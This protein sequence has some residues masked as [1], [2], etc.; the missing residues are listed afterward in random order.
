M[1]AADAVPVAP[2]VPADEQAWRALAQAVVERLARLHQPA[3]EPGS[4][5]AAEIERADAS[6]DAARA[7]FRTMLQLPVPFAT[8][9]DNARLAPADAE[10]L[11]VAVGCELDLRLARLIGALQDEVGPSRL[12][13]QIADRILRDAG[14]GVAAAIGLEAP[15]RRARLV[16]VTEDGPWAQHAVVVHPGVIWALV[17][18]TA[19]D[20]GLPLGT[21][22][23]DDDDPADD[24]H[25]FVL[26]S[27]PD[28]IRRRE[29]A[30]H[31]AAA[32]RFLVAPQPTE[33]A[34]WDALVR[35][36]TLSGTGVIIELPDDVGAELTPDGKRTIAQAD[37]LAWGVTAR[38]ELPIG[39]M[40][41]RSWV[42]LE[43]PGH[44]ATDE[45]WDAAVGPQRERIHRLSPTQLDLVGKA[46]VARGGDLDAA[47]RR[48][49]S[50]RLEQLAQRMR[51]TRTWDDIVLSPARLE[52][53]RGIVDRYRYA[54]VVY[55]RWGFV[56][57]P[58]RG[59]VSLFSGPS[60]TGKTL[61]AEI[62]AGDLGLDVFKLD[63]SSVVSKYIGETEKNLEQIFEAAGGSNVVL[64]FDEADSLFGKRSE[65]KD[66]RDRYANIEVSYLLQRLERYDGVVVLATNFEK[67][68]DEAF[69]RRIHTRVEFVVPAEEE[70]LT[71]WTRNFPPDAP[72]GDIDL[73]FLAKRFEL[74]GGSIRNAAVHAAFLAASQESPITMELTVRAIAREMR[75]L[76][77]LLK[78]EHFGP[79][80]DA[81]VATD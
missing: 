13:L 75:K 54:S 71:I 3:A 43:A 9:A 31:H 20:P 19:V 44:A 57:Q 58:S 80:F 70:R 14:S 48:L 26:V 51:P 65:V 46:W 49:V 15:L 56:P 62:I 74:S 1:A 18:D 64:F 50:G 72:L 76:G 52:Q 36:A 53:L 16:D 47:V 39:E 77:R 25:A 35:E 59:L 63:L 33:R 28:R 29:T 45:E 69:L 27:G 5:A 7:A 2:A 21:V 10:L 40:P 17:G 41:M 60:G 66:A 67:N 11:A 34:G 38:R 37:H 78:P 8:I 32:S 24:Q 79:W 22:L 23:V 68:I 4:V 12:T 6:V 73:P 61:A 81:A 55:D 30:V 42:E